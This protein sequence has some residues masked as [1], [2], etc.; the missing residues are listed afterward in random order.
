[1]KPC[2]SIAAFGRV[3]DRNTSFGAYAVPSGTNAIAPGTLSGDVS[4]NVNFANNTA[5]GSLTNMKAQAVGSSTTTPWNDF[6]LS[7]TLIRGPNDVGM[8]GP[9][10]T[11][12]NA[13]PAGLS[14]AA[15]GSFSGALYGPAA[16][17]VAGGWNRKQP[18][19]AAR[20]PLGHS[21]PTNNR[22]L[23]VR[24]DAPQGLRRLAHEQRIGTQR[25]SGPAGRCR[26][27]RVCEEKT[28]NTSGVEAYEGAR[29]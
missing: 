4:L 9:T 20:L 26:P 15:H 17:E 19:A 14:S 2:R 22:M 29:F 27:F 25:F 3:D 6:S 11:S 24:R 21:A 1:L 13:G 5:N 10:S 16:Q 12:G 28:E 7:G 8:S 23:A 18:R